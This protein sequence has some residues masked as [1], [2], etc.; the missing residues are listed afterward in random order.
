[1]PSWWTRPAA[2]WSRTAILTRRL[3]ADLSPETRIARLRAPLFL[4][5]GR[6]DPAV[7][8]TESLR[9]E[10]AARTSGQRVDTAIIGSVGHV[11][12]EHRAGP[13]DL[14]RLW[15]AFYAFEVTGRVTRAGLTSAS[16]AP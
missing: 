5:H 15:A 12:P 14:V 6:D 2:A 3:L 9:L 13:R 7:P 10:R 1:M 11:E 4:I 16:R 8:F